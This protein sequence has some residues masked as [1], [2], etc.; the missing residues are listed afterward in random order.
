[1]GT[2]KTSTWNLSTAT[3]VDTLEKDESREKLKGKKDA[4]AEDENSLLSNIPKKYHEWLHFFRK[5]AI[6]LPQH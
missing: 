5:D 4:S 2:S 1:M 6:T 3:L